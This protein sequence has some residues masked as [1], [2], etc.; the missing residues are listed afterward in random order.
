MS[1]VGQIEVSGQAATMPLTV[2][3]TRHFPGRTCT[4]RFAR[5]AAV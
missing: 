4:Y 1:Q 3:G 2:A 5:R